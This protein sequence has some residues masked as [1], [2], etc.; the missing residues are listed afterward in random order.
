MA[1]QHQPEAKAVLVAKADANEKLSLVLV[2][3]NR[4]NEMRIH[5][6]VVSGIS[7]HSGFLL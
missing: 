4:Q 5:H 2:K 7:I 3:E 6:L 1:G